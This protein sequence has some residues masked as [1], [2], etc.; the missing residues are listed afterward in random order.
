MARQL[1]AGT[2]TLLFTDIEGS[3]R[4]LQELGRER[5]VRALAEHR[6]LLRDTFAAYGGVEVEMQG[7]S[8]HFAFASAREGV[9]AAAAAQQALAGHAWEVEPVRVRMGL[10]TGEPIQADGLYAG[11]DVHRAARVMSAGHGGQVIVSART[12]DLVEGEL[13]LGVALR[14]LGE[15]RLKDLSLPQRL[16]DLVIHRLPFEFPPPKTLENRPTNLPVQST[17]LIGRER[18]LGELGELLGRR[19]VCLVTLTGPGGTGKTRLAQAASELVEQFRGG[20]FFVG[21]APLGQAQLVLPT[22]AQTLGVREVPGQGLLE[23]LASFLRKRKLLLL[24][25]NFEHLTD[26]APDVADLLASSPGLKV[27]VTSRTPLRLSGEHEFS[28][29]PLALPETRA[30]WQ[31]EALSQYAAVR[32]FTERARSVKTGFAVTSANA[33]AVAEICRRLDGLPLALELAAARLRI[34]SPQGLLARLDER[35]TLLTGG[36]RDLDERQQTLRA[37][38]D[39]SY[40]LLS[41]H[42]QSL[43]ARLAVFSGSFTLEAAE[44]VCGEGGDS[45]VVEALAQLVEQSLLRQQDGR[46]GE[47]RFSMLETI[48]EYACER[49]LARRDG[50]AVKGRHF[51]YFLEAA[52]ES[53]RI[54]QE[55]PHV[56][57]Y[58]RLEDE[59][60][61]LRA[62]LEWCIQQGE[63]RHALAALASLSSY[64]VA[65]GYVAEGDRFAGQL[66]AVAGVAEREQEGIART[67]AGELARFVGDLAR[68]AAL[69]EAALEQLRDV[70]PRLAGRTARDLA[71]VVLELGDLRRAKR[72]AEEAVRLQSAAGRPDDRAHALQGVALIEWHENHHGEAIRLMEE[73]TRAWK[74]SGKVAPWADSQVGLADF[75]RRAGKL[76]Q[77][78]AR[79]EEALITHAEIGDTFGTLWCLRIFGALAADE[80]RVQLAAKIWGATE[81]GAYKSGLSFGNDPPDYEEKLTQL[82]LTLGDTDFE[83]VWSEGS[84]MTPEEAA[85][86]ALAPG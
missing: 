1:P 2:V 30:S 63:R 50:D 22:V 20:V 21:L 55:Q 75:L 35:L 7:D 3:T 33:S 17:P 79:L 83:R 48:H 62:S 16:Y 43:F 29:P 45:D 28:V 81:G 8:F 24:L 4:L 86:V 71:I 10:H 57:A 60:D 18:E 25:D 58:E 82:R 56:R 44:A 67:H 12:A 72:F 42:E 80:G 76:D 36:A 6:R 34:L 49:L 68:A 70:N 46:D 23:T 77:A 51:E 84:R 74:E 27:L 54:A 64:W 13:P 66:L 65:R 5:Y 39:W 31:P 38:I 52:A 41:A 32:L 61:N 11:L 19:E 73:A 14:D 26:A 40:R 15:H 78:R 9:A 59:H 47:P 85:R 37:A 53:A 69:K